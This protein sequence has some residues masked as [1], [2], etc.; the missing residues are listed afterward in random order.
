MVGEVIRYYRQK[1]RMM[2]T[3]IAEITGLSSN[4][5]YDIENNIVQNPPLEILSKIAYTLNI[6]IDMLNECLT[7]N[8]IKKIDQEWMYLLNQAIQYGVN[9]TDLLSLILDKMK[10]GQA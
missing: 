1:H 8:S 9:K 5:L 3:D 6:S 2:L 7:K 10:K 4:Y